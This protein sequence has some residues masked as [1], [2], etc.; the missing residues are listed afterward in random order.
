MTGG[1][2]PVGQAERLGPYC[3]GERKPLTKF[4]QRDIIRWASERSYF[5]AIV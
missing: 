4:H 5:R 3:E 2:A 1:R